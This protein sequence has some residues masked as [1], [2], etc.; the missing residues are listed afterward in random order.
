MPT[1]TETETEIETTSAKAAR[2]PRLVLFVGFPG[3]C[4]L[5][6]AGPQTVFWCA[7]KMMQERGLPGY[8]RHTVSLDGG[9]VQTL[10]GVGFQTE[11]V[12]DFLHRAVDTIVV[13]GA[14][15]I[16]DA[17]ARSGA[18]VAWLRLRAATARRTASVCTGAFLL[19]AAG[20][21]D[22]KRAAT[23]WLM[24][25][26]LRQAY[27]LIE[28]DR[29]AIFVQH[30]ATWTSGGVTAGIDLA[31]ALVEQDCGRE[32]ALAVA[33]ELVVFVKRP[34]GHPQLSWML[35]A[36]SKHGPLF[37]E[38]HM[39]I[40]QNLAEPD[41]GVELLAG[42]MQMSPRNF[43]RVYKEKTGLTPAKAVENFRIEAARRLL[44]DSDRNIDQVALLCG[45]GDEGRMRKTF[46]RHLQL[47]PT[48][49]RQRLLA[50]DGAAHA[51]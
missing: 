2:Q 42:R 44:E 3:M 25:D 27:P 12:D 9:M 38:L 23:H 46:Q 18:L 20:L 41:L 6:I 40:L 51:A 50:G 5:D 19:A 13:P 7:S 30:G 17:I 4:M 34:S 8:A 39:W 14:P 45:F 48:E 36:Q 1:K 31:L 16:V 26:S 29:E 49:Y 43:T 11:A 35:Q 22:G 24:S 21:L 32:V 47:S 28:V 15:D 33:R 10:E 37:D